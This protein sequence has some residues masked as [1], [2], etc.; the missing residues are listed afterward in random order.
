MRGGLTVALVPPAAAVVPS[1]LWGAWALD[2]ST[3]ALVAATVLAYAHTVRGLWRSGGRGAGIREAQ[4]VW[5]GLGVVA[6][7]VALVSPLEALA[8]SLFAAH[9]VQHLLLTLVAAPLLLLGRVHLGVLPVLPVSWRRHGAR[10][11]AR[12][13]RTNPGI[14]V[15]AVA[16][17]VGT[18]LAWHVPALYDAAVARTGLHVLEHATLLLTALAFWVVM[19]AARPRPVAAAGLAAFVASLVSVLLAATMTAATHPWYASHLATAPAW[20]LTALQD[21][22]LAAAI[23]WVPGGIVYLSAAG[24]AVYRWIRA[25]ERRLSLRRGAAR[26]P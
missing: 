19:G 21:Q 22:H 7:L 12:T 6:V 16:L 24:V 25:D 17:H 14:P 13:V 18:L 9:M 5:F 1:A 15:A 20:G 10:V 2:P 11:V 4:V 26:Q 23:M 8:A 3:L